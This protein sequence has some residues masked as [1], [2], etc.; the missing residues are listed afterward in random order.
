VPVLSGTDGIEHLVELL[1]EDRKSWEGTVLLCGDWSTLGM[2]KDDATKWASAVLDVEGPD[3]LVQRRL[4]AGLI[5][6]GGLDS[7]GTKAEPTRFG[8]TAGNQKF[9]KIVR[10]LNSKAVGKDQLWDALV[11]SWA[12]AVSPG[13]VLRWDP[14]DARN[15]AYRATDPSGEAPQGV[16]GANWLAFVG[17][18]YFPVGVR[19]RR[20]MTTAFEGSGKEE[21]F[22]W[23]LWQGPLASVVVRSLL[24][25][26][27]LVTASQRERMLRGVR[28]VLRSRV[29]RVGQGYGNFGA[30]EQC[31]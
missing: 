31:G 25:D 20:V 13:L 30:A 24:R 1:D 2:P 11:G 17:L 19:H 14:R 10:E 12:N 28:C 29:Y 5:T 15:F 7:S 4:L 9:L 23:P 21:S 8:F 6:D 3:G 27:S 22:V 26:S 16:P 18:S